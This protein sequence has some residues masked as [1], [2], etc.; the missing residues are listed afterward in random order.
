MYT[1]KN[2]IVFLT[3]LGGLLYLQVFLSNR[4]NKFKGL[5]LPILN[6]VISLSII[7]LIMGYTESS[8]YNILLFTGMILEFLQ[9]NIPTVILLIIYFIIREKKKKHS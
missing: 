5:I 6:F 8:E 4:E 9:W 3:F 2:L 7:F 1:I